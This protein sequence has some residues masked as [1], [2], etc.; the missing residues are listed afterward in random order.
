MFQSRSKQR[1]IFVLAFIA[2]LASV[3]TSWN[4]KVLFK[5][6]TEE[7]ENDVAEVSFCKLLTTVYIV[8]LLGSGKQP[9]VGVKKE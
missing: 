1:R 8:A 9:G 7:V 3:F 4:M 5:V 2:M 6:I